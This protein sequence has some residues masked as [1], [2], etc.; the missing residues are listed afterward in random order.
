M[1]GEADPHT[2]PLDLLLPQDSLV[3][4]YALDLYNHG[5][6]WEAHVYFEALWNAHNRVGSAADFFKGMIKLSAAGVKLRLNQK[7]LA[8]EHFQRAMDLFKRIQSDEGDMFLGFNLVKIVQDLE[9]DELE[10]QIFPA[11]D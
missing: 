11:W 2:D 5:Y 3:L 9:F 7:T 6:F 10:M 8:F 4:R 1:E